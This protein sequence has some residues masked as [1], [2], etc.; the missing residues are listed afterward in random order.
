M[1]IIK[2]HLFIFVVIGT[3][4]VLGTIFDIT[5]PIKYIIKLPCPTCGMTRALISLIKL[6]FKGYVEYNFMAFFM[7]TAV[8]LLIHRNIFKKKRWIKWYSMLVL[9]VNLLVYFICI[10]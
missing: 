1:R 10:V 8:M 9:L 6:D 4:F 7:I 3:Y 5:C 2:K